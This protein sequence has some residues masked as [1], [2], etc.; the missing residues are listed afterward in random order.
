MPTKNARGAAENAEIWQKNHGQKHLF[1]FDLFACFLPPH[2][3][4]IRVSYEAMA[5]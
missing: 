1:A 3:L 2:S 4:R 5:N